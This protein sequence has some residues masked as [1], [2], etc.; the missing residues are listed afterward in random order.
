MYLSFYYG[1]ILTI[2]CYF[3]LSSVFTITVIQ[4]DIFSLKKIFLLKLKYIFLTLKYIVPLY[5]K[6]PFDNKIPFDNKSKLKSIMI[7][8][9]FPLMYKIFFQN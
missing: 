6:V 5:N 3:L 2:I 7:F 1:F 8:S 9:Y 4:W